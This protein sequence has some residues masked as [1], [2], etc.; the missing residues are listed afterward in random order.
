MDRPVSFIPLRTTDPLEDDFLDVPTTPSSSSS[1]SKLTRLNGLALVISLQIGSGIF[2]A[3][4]QV[5]Q[6]V[7]NP[8][9]GLL[10]WLLGGLLVWT[11][12]ASFIELGLRVP[13]NGGIQEYLRTCYGD[14]WGF[15]FTFMWCALAKPAANAII[16]TI[17]A[18]Y[19]LS[20]F[21]ETH[22]PLA[23]KG[24]ALLCIVG[25][26]T[27]NCLGSTA[28]AKAANL[29]LV[30]K[31]AALGGVVVIGGVTWAW[32]YGEGV[33]LSDDGWFGIPAEEDMVIWSSAGLGNVAT[34]LFGALFCYGGWETVG[35][36]LGDMRDPEGDLPVVINGAM[37]TVITGF[38]LMNAAT[39]V[40]LPWQVIRGSST[41]AVEFARRT[42]GSWG[43]LAFSVAV[44]ISAMGALNANVFAT[45]KLCVA[46][47][48][49][50]YFPA[51]LANLHVPFAGDEALYL[52]RKLRFLPAP[53]RGAV[54]GFANMTREL[55]WRR[56]VP[57]YALIM[58]GLM[59]SFYVLI[60]SFNGLVTFIGL[61]EYFFF[62]LSVIGLLVLRQRSGLDPKYRTWTGNPVI[63]TVVSGLLILRGLLTE[64][65]QGFAIAAAGVLGLAVFYWNSKRNGLPGPSPMTVMMP[66]P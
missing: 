16:S 35:F 61:A 19:L 65:L 18:D 51:I 25:I 55:R 24:L 12:A 26:T 48:Q 63:F 6:H 17:F 13:G 36:V 34:A 50:T 3:P 58:N 45:A 44:S 14:A 7:P 5:S 37:A 1:S 66:V 31:L 8:G 38:C 4:S 41:V 53:V 60:G 59:A 15:L 52:D 43:A 23:V 22:S 20:S 2:T 40:C 30:L 32:G 56:A 64:P 54:V 39:Y 28:G 42:L 10:V 21:L 33:P 62:L 27:V 57:I 49:R 29:F 11:G 47:A 46:A 9:S